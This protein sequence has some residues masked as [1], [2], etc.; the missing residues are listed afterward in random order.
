MTGHRLCSRFPTE[1]RRRDGWRPAWLSQVSV[2]SSLGHWHKP[3]IK[4]QAEVFALEVRFLAWHPTRLKRSTAVTV[5]CNWAAHSFDRPGWS[6]EFASKYSLEII[7]KII[8]MKWWWWWW[9]RRRR[10]WWW[11]H[12]WRKK[13]NNN[14]YHS[15]LF[16]DDL[17]NN[18]NN[19]RKRTT[20]VSNLS[21][22]EW[23]QQQ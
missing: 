21:S 17:Y 23:Q 8:I 1:W 16:R 3:P 19:G 15:V 20:T 14:N 9:R 5:G 4:L 6:H 13:K 11:W 12:K 22:L 2:W 10:W 18:N 7:V